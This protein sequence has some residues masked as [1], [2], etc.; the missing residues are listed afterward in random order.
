MGIDALQKDGAALHGA[1][2]DWK[3]VAALGIAIAISGNFSGWNYGLAV[4]GWRGMFVAALAMA[5]L[6]FFLAQALAE[7]AAA[8]PE[9]AGFDYYVRRAWNPL[10]GYLCGI[11]LA[12]ALAIG[13]GLAASFAEAYWASLTGIG[14]WPVKLAL[15]AIVIVLQLRGARDVA[16][17]T[18]ITGAFVLA[19]LVA[20][21]V[22]A[23]PF[24]QVSN[25]GILAP[26]NHPLSPST[27]LGCIPFALFLF[28]GV[29][30][31]AQAA[32]ETQDLIRTMPRALASAVIVAVTIGLCVLCL[33][34]GSAGVDA[35]GKSD[36]PLF[37]AVS[38]HSSSPGA[39]VMRHI[40]SL[41][42]LVALIAT[43]F[44]LAYAGSRQFYH[45]AN[46]GELPRGLT[47]T[48][49][50]RVPT[51]ALF[52]T[53][54]IGLA[55][56]AFRPDVVMVGF[57]FLISVA[58]LLVSISFIRLR[59]TQPDLTRPYRAIGGIPA[60]AT[61]A[62]LSAV[63]IASCYELQPAALGWAFAGPVSALAYFL[64]TRRSRTP[65]G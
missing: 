60:V 44:S 11:T 18:M 41:G 4:G 37:T 23:L 52:L 16:A 34:T 62:C 17:T 63:V 1:A 48:N 14:G 59:Q 51:G 6:F 22:F 27:M 42:A 12:L 55:A 26:Q 28:L 39:A 24:F 3:R 58:H 47:V 13:T 45:L 43:F 9:G 64:V 5:F 29:E 56:S 36:D 38:S 20:F 32:A 33:A 15:F 46:A 40:V 21:C 54:A 7:L 30:Q 35:L 8:Y 50:H 2:L 49:K 53:T 10:L 25:L 65:A 57:I 61:A 31:S 19:V